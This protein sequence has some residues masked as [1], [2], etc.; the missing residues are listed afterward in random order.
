MSMPDIDKVPHLFPP[1]KKHPMWPWKEMQD[2]QVLQGRVISA[3]RAPMKAGYSVGAPEALFVHLLTDAGE[4]TVYCTQ[5]IDESILMELGRMGLPGLQRGTK[6]W[7]QK[8][9]TPESSTETEDGP[10]YRRGNIRYDVYLME[11]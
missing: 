3:W 4:W 6:L 10:V 1:Y 11:P 9:V 2:K 5:A 7:I 8:L